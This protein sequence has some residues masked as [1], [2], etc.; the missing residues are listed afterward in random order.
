MICMKTTTCTATYLKCL[1]I[2]CSVFLAWVA[3]NW[4]AYCSKAWSPTPKNKRLKAGDR[5]TYLLIYPGSSYSEHKFLNETFVSHSSDILEI[6][7]YGRRHTTSHGNPIVWWPDDSSPKL[8]SLECLHIRRNKVAEELT[9]KTTNV[10][11]CCD[12]KLFS[13]SR[14]PVCY[15]SWRKKSHKRS[16]EKRR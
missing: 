4:D 3:L 12:K 11:C 8:P 5:Q 15:V 13:R 16:R 9:Q 10:E 1:K 6:G 7:T 2:T 14:L